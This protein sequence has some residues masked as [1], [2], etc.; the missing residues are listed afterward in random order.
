ML[1]SALACGVPSPRAAS[2]LVGEP[3]SCKKWAH[4]NLYPNVGNYTPAG[5]WVPYDRV[6]CSSACQ[7]CG[8]QLC[9]AGLGPMPWKLSIGHCCLTA[10]I[11]KGV[12]C[13]TPPCIEPPAPPPPPAPKAD[14]IIC[15]V[16][17]AAFASGKLQTIDDNGTVDLNSIKNFIISLGLSGDGFDNLPFPFSL[18]ELDGVPGGAFPNGVRAIGH[19]SALSVLLSVLRAYRDQAMEHGLSSGIRDPHKSKAN[20]DAF[21]AFADAEGTFGVEGMGAAGKWF[22]EHPNHETHIPDLNRSGVEATFVNFLL[23]VFG[24]CGT[25]TRKTVNP[26]TEKEGD[27]VKTSDGRSVPCTGERLFMLQE[28]LEA[29]MWGNQFPKGFRFQH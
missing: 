15:P 24:R 17:A 29:L 28:D 8:G 2:A 20:L 21:M 27:V 23:P 9:D 3:A 25:T 10:I 6:C 18:F 14:R 13:G 1:A 5:E 16:L 11:E 22:D 19:A 7:Y 26:Y 12:A 4:V